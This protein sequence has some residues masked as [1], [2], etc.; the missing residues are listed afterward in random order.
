M[1]YNYEVNFLLFSAP[2]IALKFSGNS[3][4]LWA[5]GNGNFEDGFRYVLYTT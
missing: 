5:S 3:E 1:K 2:Y 4:V